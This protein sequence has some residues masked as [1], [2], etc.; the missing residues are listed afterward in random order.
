MHQGIPRTWVYFPSLKSCILSKL[1][2]THFLPSQPTRWGY[3]YTSM[4][5]LLTFCAV[6]FR[7]A[8]V[9]NGITFLANNVHTT[10]ALCCCCQMYVWTSGFCQSQK[11]A[12]SSAQLHVCFEIPLLLVLIAQRWRAK[13]GSALRGTARTMQGVC[14]HGAGTHVMVVDCIASWHGH[15]STVWMCTALG[16]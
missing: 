10:V 1:N 16:R 9:F 15:A 2:V 6:Y 14:M 8:A 11:Y 12:V 4:P 13:Y 3:L 5:N 7:K